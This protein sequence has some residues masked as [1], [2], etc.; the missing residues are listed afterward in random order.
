[1]NSKRRIFARVSAGI[2][3]SLALLAVFNLGPGVRAQTETSQGWSTPVNLSRSGA[4]TKPALVIDQSGVYHM[5][6]RDEFTGVMYS[7]G[8]GRQWSEPVSIQLPSG[9]AMPTLVADQNGF[10]HAFWIVED[11]TFYHSRVQADN[12]TMPQ[13]WSGRQRVAASALD[14]AVALDS[15]GRLHLGYVRP[16]ETETN[17]A[18]VYYTRLEPGDLRWS[19][20]VAVYTSPYFRALTGESAHIEI[21][22]ANIGGAEN[23]YLVWDNRPRDAA[24]LIH[25]GDGGVTWSEVVD[26]EGGEGETPAPSSHVEI[27]AGA[28]D[29]FLIWQE[30]NPAISC[31]QYYQHSTDGGEVWSER[32]PVFS[33]VLGCPTATE[34]LPGA[35][36][37]VLIQN[38]IQGQVYLQAWDGSRWS[39]PQLQPEMTSFVDPETSSVISLGCRQS[40]IV[41]GSELLLSGCD[42]GAG[43]DIWIL[44]RSL[45]D[46]ANWFPTQTGWNPLIPV[47]SGVGEFR[48]PEVVV[49]KEGL[50]HVFWSEAGQVAPDSPGTDLYYARF[51]NERWSEPVEI[52]T[53]ARGKAEQIDATLDAHGR[54]LA[55]WSGGQSGEIFFS[56]VN[57]RDALLAAEWARPLSLPSPQPAGSSPEILA[58]PDGTIYVVY[59]IPLNEVRGI[60]LTRSTD[61]GL[62]W[63]EPV[64]VVDAQ[65]AGWSMVD[66]P[67]LAVTENGSLHVLWTQYTLPG[68]LGPLAMYY[69]RSDDGGVT[70]SNPAT[71]TDN[72]V[73]WSQLVSLPDGRLHRVWQE[74]NDV[75]TT[76]WH[77][78]STDNGA[79]WQRTAPVSIFGDTLGTPG[80]AWD[81]ARRLHLL[82]MVRS[83]PNAYLFQHWVWNG[84]SW[85]AEDSLN[86]QVPGLSNIGQVVADMSPDGD[87]ALIF[88]GM[89]PEAESGLPQD[90]LYFA[91]RE[92]DVPAPASGP[93]TSAIADTG[94]TPVPS[95]PASTGEPEESLATPTL[96]TALVDPGPNRNND[97]WFGS[98]LGPV[99]AG[100]IIF[101]LIFVGILFRRIRGA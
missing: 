50:F 70:W 30:G 64:R 19:D 21:D 82:Q 97:A 40:Q 92:M 57:A 15:A 61:G 23:V 26:L 47:A 67:R 100:L 84:E 4:A 96:P 98:V 88:T 85:G 94:A 89:S 49:E 101:G 14:Y 41:G 58:A 3:L 11:N 62:T 35:D 44:R 33:G 43:K 95:T 34:I 74:L 73:Y 1:M 65:A 60:Y 18:G 71:V 6:W 29:Q 99:A 22:T 53:A 86:I 77:E 12:I 48:T 24:H 90:M 81:Q 13:A 83:N 52:L 39:D 45:A 2:L 9:G 68:G 8:N 91:D 25:S 93:P 46:T 28:E 87:L 63:A 42:Q 59:A 17:L 16:L 66:Q 79:T 80:L 55:A 78:T 54:L 32:Q 37:Q 27:F 69:S 51:E 7:T 31:A 20:P 56:A 38:E 10:I 76:L 72:P 75:R 5:I 36:R